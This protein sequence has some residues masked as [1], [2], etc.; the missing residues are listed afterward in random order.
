[1]RSGAGVLALVRR[2]EEAPPTKQHLGARILFWFLVGMVILAFVVWVVQVAQESSQHRELYPRLRIEA[3]YPDGAPCRGLGITVA[4]GDA[5]IPLRKATDL[6][7]VATY[8]VPKDDRDINIA[9]LSAGFRSVDPSQ[10]HLDAIPPEGYTVHV[11][12]FK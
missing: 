1:V 2:S 6:R 3:A 9:F 7:G 4:Y 11:T 10:L 5:Q 12:V 8:N